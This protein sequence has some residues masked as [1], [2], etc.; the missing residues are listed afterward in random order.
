[1]ANPSGFRTPGECNQR[2]AG[3]PGDPLVCPRRS[4]T[5]L[6]PVLAASDASGPAGRKQ[7]SGLKVRPGRT[8]GAVVAGPVKKVTFR[9]LVNTRRER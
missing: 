3:S 6:A 7:V 5:F 2:E 1:M 9:E 8:D 4:P